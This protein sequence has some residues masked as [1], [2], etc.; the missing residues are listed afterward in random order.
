M[1]KSVTRTSTSTP[2]ITPSL[3]PSVTSSPTATE[4]VTPSL[5][6]NPTATPVTKLEV[7]VFDNFT[8]NGGGIAT[9]SLI[10]V[11][12]FNDVSL[13]LLNKSWG[14]LRARCYFVPD[15]VGTTLKFQG[16]VLEAITYGTINGAVINYG[17]VFNTKVVG[18][19]MFCE[20]LNLY[21]EPVPVDLYLYLI[22]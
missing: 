6:P 14:Q 7:K 15:G 10:D 3:T 18:P 16:T 1:T 9:S 13:F 11:S 19:N 2:S 8:V 12:S 21:T 5:T 22:P 20:V 4:T 17:S